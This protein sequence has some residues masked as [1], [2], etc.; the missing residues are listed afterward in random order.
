MY[1]DTV[2]LFN[3]RKNKTGTIWY[4]TILKNVDLNVDKASILKTYGADA[5]DNA[6]LH[7]RYTNSDGNIIIGD[8]TYVKP[9]EWARTDGASLIT[10]TTGNGFDFFYAGAWKDEMPINDSDYVSSKYE[11]FYDYMNSYYDE[12]YSLSQ[13]S[14][15]SVIPHFEILAK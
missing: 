6:V 3:R 1:K 2:T 10:F 8:K 15:F 14:R 9:K 4:P 11:G 7:I 12:I 5:T 13:V